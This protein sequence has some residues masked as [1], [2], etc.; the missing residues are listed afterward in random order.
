MSRDLL[1]ARDYLKHM[2]AAV[3]QIQIYSEGKSAKEFLSDRLLQD[4]IILNFEVLG[5]ASRNLLDLSIDAPSRFPAIPFA[6]IYAPRNQLSHGY[7]AVDLDIVW[8]VIERDIP[9]LRKELEAA[10]ASLNTAPNG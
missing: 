10:A 8:K 2:I 6:A 3:S 1:R 5:E 7:F 4:A 9:P